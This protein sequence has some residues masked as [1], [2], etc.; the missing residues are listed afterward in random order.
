MA[1]GTLCV[2]D[3]VTRRHIELGVKGE[4]E[5]ARKGFTRM[6]AELN[7]MGAEFTDI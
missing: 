2:G 5:Q 7:T 4:P 6:L 3:A 1:T